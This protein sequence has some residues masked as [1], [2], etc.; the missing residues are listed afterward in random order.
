MKRNETVESIEK[1]KARRKALIESQNY[2]GPKILEKLKMHCPCCAKRRYVIAG[3]INAFRHAERIE[4]FNK[5]AEFYGFQQA[6][7]HNAVIH[8][9]YDD[10]RVPLAA[11]RRKEK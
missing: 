5:M 1:F 6:C 9:G 11:I 8:A 7:K 3:F 4:Q 10:V 2:L